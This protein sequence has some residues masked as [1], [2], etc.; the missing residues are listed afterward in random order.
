MKACLYFASLLF[1]LFCALDIASAETTPEES[2]NKLGKFA[3]VE[4]LLSEVAVNDGRI[5]LNFGGKFPDHIFVAMAT[6]DSAKEFDLAKLKALEGK[7]V[8]V[9]GRIQL[10]Q[11]KPAIMLTRRG[12]V[13]LSEKEEKGKDSGLPKN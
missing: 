11:G 4:G 1:S 3:T 10:Y 2:I 12:Q 5:F 13:S 8:T 6:V 7:K 9:S